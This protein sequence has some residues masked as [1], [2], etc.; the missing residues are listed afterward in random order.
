VIQGFLMFRS[1]DSARAFLYT[2]RLVARH[3]V[4]GLPRWQQVAS[5]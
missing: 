2:E 1:P 5:K 3:S 4:T